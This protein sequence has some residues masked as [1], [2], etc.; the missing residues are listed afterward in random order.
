MNHAQDFKEYVRAVR[1]A[2]KERHGIDVPYTALRASLLSVRGR[3]PHAAVFPTAR[4]PADLPADWARLTSVYCAGFNLAVYSRPVVERGTPGWRYRAFVHTHGRLVELHSSR[5]SRRAST[6]RLEPLRQAP[7]RHVLEDLLASN[8]LLER[9]PSGLPFEYALNVDGGNPFGSNFLSKE[10]A[11]RA[12]DELHL[13][14]RTTAATVV[15]IFSIEPDGTQA[16]D[17]VEE[18]GLDRWRDERLPAIQAEFKEAGFAR[19]LRV[20]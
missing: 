20:A 3:S 1:H 18:W 9:R 4:H 19:R 15:S 12:A 7:R 11:L 8:G 16:P 13:S 10:L 5:P 14:G 17:E 2:L 6:A